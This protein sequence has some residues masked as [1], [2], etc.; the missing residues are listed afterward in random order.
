MGEVHAG[1]GSVAGNV[2]GGCYARGMDCCDLATGEPCK[3]VDRLPAGAGRDKIELAAMLVGAVAGVR[4]APDKLE[5]PDRTSAA[6]QAM[7]KRLEQVTKATATIEARIPRIR[8][9]QQANVIAHGLDT[10][11]CNIAVGRN[12]LELAIAE[13]LAALEDG[14]RAM[15]LKY[16]NIGDYAREELGMNA[17]TAAKKA[18]LARKL[19]GRA[20]PVLESRSCGRGS[21]PRLTGDRAP[22]EALGP[23]RGS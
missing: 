23:G 7:E 13:G 21:M 14:R 10:L 3:G 15:D 4:T 5:F 1:V 16:S 22:F 20:A 8:D 18:R 9:P 17:S 19:R 6:W 2:G 12:A 11:L